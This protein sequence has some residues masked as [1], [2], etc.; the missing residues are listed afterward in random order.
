MVDNLAD[1]NGGACFTHT[2]A[3]PHFENCIAYNNSPQDFFIGSK[4]LRFE[5]GCY[6]NLDDLYGLGVI[7][8]GNLPEGTDPLLN[9]GEDYHLQTT[10]PCIDSGDNSF[11][12][13]DQD[14]DLNTRIQDGT[15]D[16]GCYES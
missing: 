16:M 11:V 6:G 5:S 1:F 7:G 8:S 4:P 2:Y 10:S 12:T 15:V 14:L 3:D 13:T 9:G